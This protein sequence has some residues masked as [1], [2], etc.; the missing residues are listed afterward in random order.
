[1]LGA[2]QHPCL[3]FG[4]GPEFL[5]SLDEVVK[6]LLYIVM[7]QLHVLISCMANETYMKISSSV[8]FCVFV[9]V[10]TRYIQEYIQEYISVS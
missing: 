1:M 2:P 4:I 9:R 5:G 3:H 10:H 6:S 8:I 7:S